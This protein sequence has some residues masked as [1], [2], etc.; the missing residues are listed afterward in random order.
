MVKILRKKTIVK[1]NFNEDMEVEEE[2]GYSS[3]AALTKA[4]K[5][6]KFL[7]PKNVLIF[8]PK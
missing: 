7:D 1:N 3:M 2:L 8:E 6:N 5:H 4:F